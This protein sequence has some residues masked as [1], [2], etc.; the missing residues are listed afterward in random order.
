[1]NN[2]RFEVLTVVTRKGWDETLNSLAESFRRMYDAILDTED[3]GSTFL[4][5]AGKLLPDY[6]MSHLRIQHSS[7]QCFPGYTNLL[8]ISV[9]FL[10]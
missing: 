7:K 1:M 9:Y 3:K 4:Q 6:M 2:L 5:N 8:V 10:C